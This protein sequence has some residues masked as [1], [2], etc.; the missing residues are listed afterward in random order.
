[1]LPNRYT[2]SNTNQMEALKN[3][4]LNWLLRGY[5]QLAGIDYHDSF[6]P[7]AKS[8]TVRVIL[9]ISTAH[10]LPIHQLDINNA[11]LHGNLEEDVYLQC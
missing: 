3:T 7:M 9:A 4:K 6:S 10:N 8:V 2:E 5:N 1:M 11:Y